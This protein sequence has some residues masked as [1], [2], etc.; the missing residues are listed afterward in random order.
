MEMTPK[1]ETPTQMRLISLR[2]WNIAAGDDMLASA[3]IIRQVYF[4]NHLFA[5]R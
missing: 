5:I 3:R 4:F 1:I 2:L